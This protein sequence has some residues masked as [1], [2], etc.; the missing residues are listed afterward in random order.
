MKKIL[1]VLHG[2]VVAVMGVTYK[3]GTSTLRRSLPL[4]II[5]L[6]I[7]EGMTVK[8][9]DPKADYSEMI[10]PPKFLVCS[11]VT[12]AL[13]KADIAIMLTEWNEFKQI[14]WKPLKSQMSQPIVFDTKNF[15]DQKILSAA[16]FMYYS[17]GR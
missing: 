15:L 4:E 2:K 3:P 8:V 14:D 16:G 17:V 11:S 6:L 9:F 13:Q 7:D 1:N 5:D 10:T 12:E